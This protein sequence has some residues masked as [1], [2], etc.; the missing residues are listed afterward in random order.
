ME[1]NFAPRSLV[2]TWISEVAGECADETFIARVLGGGPPPPL[3]SV[4]GEQDECGC[5]KFTRSKSASAPGLSRRE[6]QARNTIAF[7]KQAAATHVAGSAEFSMRPSRFAHRA[8]KGRRSWPSCAATRSGSDSRTEAVLLSG[9]QEQ[10]L[11][12][13]SSAGF[14]RLRREAGSLNCAVLKVDD[15]LQ[16]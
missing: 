10:V 1:I 13:R 2:V 5:G 9:D 7:P 4:R 8:T 16:K 12:F 15:F 14:G 6:D 11:S 3:R